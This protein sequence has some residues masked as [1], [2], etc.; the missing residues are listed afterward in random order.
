MKAPLYALL[1]KTEV[2]QAPHTYTLSPF[3]RPLMRKLYSFVY[4]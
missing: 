4:S 3:L 1:V 2:L